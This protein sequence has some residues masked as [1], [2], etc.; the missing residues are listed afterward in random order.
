MFQIL[1][2]NVV[3]FLIV[4]KSESKK[5]IILDSK[6]YLVIPETRFRFPFEFENQK[7]WFFQM[8]LFSCKQLI[9]CNPYEF[10]KKWAFLSKIFFALNAV[11][12]THLSLKNYICNNMNPKFEPLSFS[13]DSWLN[14]FGKGRWI[15]SLHLS[16]DI[17]LS[18]VF[19]FMLCQ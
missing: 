9:W 10:L 13:L 11:M 14:T 12:P 18:M 19:Y 5:R 3:F 7:C 4:G 17:T 16:D 8:K 1:W 15:D 2:K 6:R